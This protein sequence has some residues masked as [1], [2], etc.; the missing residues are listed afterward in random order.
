MIYAHADRR[1]A[2]GLGF[3]IGAIF[4]RVAKAYHAFQ[5]TLGRHRVFRQTIDELGALS[6]RDLADLGI[7]RSMIPGIA[8]E[9]AQGP[10]AAH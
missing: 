6:D 2:H 1:G 8:M 4:H 5:E 10:D 9:A 3:G 7:S